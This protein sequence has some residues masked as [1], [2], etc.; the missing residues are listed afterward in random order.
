MKR[1]KKYGLGIDRIYGYSIQENEKGAFYSIGEVS[2]YISFLEKKVEQLK[3]SS[4]RTTNDGDRI[5]FYGSEF[6]C[7]SNF[8]SFTLNWKGNLFM[9]SEH[10]YHWEKFNT[11]KTPYIQWLIMS[12]P[13][14][15]AAYKIAAEHKDLQISN[16]NDIKVDIMYDIIWQKF[17]QHPYVRKKL[18]Q[19]ESKEIIEDSWRDD[20]WGW[21]MEQ[22]GRNELGKIWM[23]VRREAFYP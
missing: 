2:E 18:N 8:S 16:W 10:A 14:A 9:T 20:F 21:G 3:I 13:S 17:I 12:A 19:T 11:G 5:F 22:D 6:Y 7:F 4:E 23:R 15:H 1:L